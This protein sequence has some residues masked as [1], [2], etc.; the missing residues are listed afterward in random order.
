MRSPPRPAHACATGGLSELAFDVAPGRC[1][2]QACAIVGG[3][4]DDV[5]LAGASLRVCSTTRYPARGAS[6]ATTSPCVTPLTRHTTFSPIPPP[7]ST[8]RS[9]TLMVSPMRSVL[10]PGMVS[11]CGAGPEVE[12][13]L[14]VELRGRIA[15]LP[16][17]S[18]LSSASTRSGRWRWSWKLATGYFEA[19]HDF[20]HL[21]VTARSRKKPL[22]RHRQPGPIAAAN[23][24]IQ[25]SSR[26]RVPNPDRRVTTPRQIRLPSRENATELTQP[27]CPSKV[28]INWPVAT[29]HSLIVLSLPPDSACAPSGENAT[30]L[31]P[32]ACPS[33]VRSSSPVEASQSLT[34]L[35]LPVK[36]STPESKRVPSGENATDLNHVFPR[37]CG[38]ASQFRRPKAS[39]FARRPIRNASQRAT[40]TCRDWCSMPRE[41]LQ[42]L[43]GG[44]IP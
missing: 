14:Q 44:R 36:C 15:Y 10:R 18:P 28:R 34:A 9:V 17:G 37:T 3:N 13:G 7:V 21:G 2:E 29:S 22:W 23:E 38:P 31:T 16:S 5:V 6:G 19:P 39:A 11:I 4:L 12:D 26:L 20:Q 27:L 43:S 40:A 41:Y 35:S 33:K 1:G 24:V 32:R 25:V 8:R 42:Q 30:E